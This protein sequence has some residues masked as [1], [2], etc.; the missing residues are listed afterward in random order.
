MVLRE[1]LV[2]GYGNFDIDASCSLLI[3]KTGSMV[4]M[5]DPK[6]WLTFDWYL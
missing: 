2:N 4:R 5:I 3:L 6:C 1:N